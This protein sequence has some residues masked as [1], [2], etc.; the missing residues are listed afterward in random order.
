MIIVVV[1]WVFI[2][3]FNCRFIGLVEFLVFDIFEIVI[4]VIDIVVEDMI[5]IINFCEYLVF[6]VKSR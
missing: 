1:G 4:G 6:I 2:I 5:K 3:E